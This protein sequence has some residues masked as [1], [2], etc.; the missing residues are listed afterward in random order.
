MIHGRVGT[1]DTF[2]KHARL[3]RSEVL[4]FDLFGLFGLSGVFKIA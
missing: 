4:D 3:G 1:N 2:R